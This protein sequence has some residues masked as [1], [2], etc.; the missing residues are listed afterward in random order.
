MAQ[1]AAVREIAERVLAPGPDA[2]VCLRLLRH[3]LPESG[4]GKQV[5]RARQ[6]LESGPWIRV[7]E[8]ERWREGSCGSFC[9]RDGPGKQ[10]IPKRRWLADRALGLGLDA[11]HRV[12]PS[13]A[14]YLTALPERTVRLPDPADTL[15]AARGYHIGAGLS[16]PSDCAPSL[17]A[18]G[19]G[20]AAYLYLGRQ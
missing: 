16:R 15:Q 9:S 20:H 5:C 19:E 7:L 13:F 8:N 12:L 4:H 1:L 6:A 14:C 11:S 10:S 18:V 2:V 17:G 3:V